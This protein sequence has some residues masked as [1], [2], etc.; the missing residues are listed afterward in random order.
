M[1]EENVDPALALFSPHVLAIPY[2]E[3]I[4]ISVGHSSLN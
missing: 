3:R 2:L 1:I 4:V